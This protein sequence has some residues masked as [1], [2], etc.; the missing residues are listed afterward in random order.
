MARAQFLTRA[1]FPTSKLR[2]KVEAIESKFPRSFYERPQ[3]PP[4]HAVSRRSVQETLPPHGLPDSSYPRIRPWLLPRRFYSLGNRIFLIITCRKHRECALIMTSEFWL[5][6]GAHIHKISGGVYWV[7]WDRILTGSYQ[8]TE[9]FL[10]L[11]PNP[12]QNSADFGH[13]KIWNAKSKKEKIFFYGYFQLKKYNESE[14]AKTRGKGKSAL[15]LRKGMERKENGDHNSLA[16]DQ[17]AG[18]GSYSLARDEFSG[19]GSLI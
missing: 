15:E 8:G 4:G 5:S 7:A 12:A 2:S 3:T 11:P 18:L 16:R 14:S 13:S 19:L 1:D 9:K 6:P 10:V 17:Y